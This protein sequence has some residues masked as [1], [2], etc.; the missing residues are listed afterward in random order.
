MFALMV[1]AAIVGPGCGEIQFLDFDDEEETGGAEMPE[2]RE[3]RTKVVSFDP[4]EKQELSG[5]GGVEVSF[6]ANALVTRGGKAPEGEARA[7]LQN[8]FHGD[9]TVMDMPG[10]SFEALQ[11]REAVALI[12]YGAVSVEIRD[13]AGN[14]LVPADGETATIGIPAT[15]EHGPDAARLWR[16]ENSGE[17]WRQKGEVELKDG[18][19]RGEVTR[20]AHWSA[21]V[22]CARACVEGFAR[23]SPWVMARVINSDCEGFR[24]GGVSGSVMV[25]DNDGHFTFYGLAGPSTVELS[26]DRDGE[27]ARRIVEVPVREGCLYAGE[28]R[29][30]EGEEEEDAGRR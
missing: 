27:V 18:T 16:L 28:L 1:A 26:W 17:K 6:A 8:Y 29:T 15:T 7:T 30:G 10:P 23:K 24:Q 12:A 14:E 20:F 21:G 3:P 19:Y 13:D 25:P 9:Y 11:D 4:A 5:A 22:P 2:A